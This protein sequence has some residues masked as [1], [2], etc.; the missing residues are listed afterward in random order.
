M[1]VSNVG[2]RQNMSLINHIF[3]IN[4]IIHETLTPKYKPVTIQVYDYKQMFDSTGL[5]EA[6]SEL[7]DSGMKDNTLALLNDANRNV[8]VK[9][10][11]QKL[12]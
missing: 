10:K 6:V 5:E 4:G 11:T 3:V 8:K 2:G 7:Y 1:S 12:I 9:V